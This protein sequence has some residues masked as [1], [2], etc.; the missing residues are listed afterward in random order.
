[1]GEGLTGFS[2]ADC[3][4]LIR[5]AALAAMRESLEAATVTAAHVETARRRVRPSLDP[6]Q[7]DAL[8]AYAGRHAIA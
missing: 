6:L 1:L 7:V 4:A 2:A 8:A 5:E 3:T